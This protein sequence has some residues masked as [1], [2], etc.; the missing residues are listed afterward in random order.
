MTQ[1]LKYLAA[2]IIFALIGGGIYAYKHQLSASPGQTTVT[3][4]IPKDPAAYEKKALND[5]EG[6][7]EQGLSTLT[8]ADFIAQK[9][10]ATTSATY[11][12]EQAS[13]DA[14]AATVRSQA[15]IKSIYFSIQGDTAYVVLN[16]DVDGWA[17]VSY[18]QSKVRPI[19]TQTLLQFPN[20]KHVIFGAE[21]KELLQQAADEYYKK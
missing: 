10:L 14:A 1:F 9:V 21:T 20:I 12:I 7:H 19:I 15:I 16:I 6:N 18:S 11:S 3:I 8:S 5:Q 2:L 4:Y 13:A 17:G